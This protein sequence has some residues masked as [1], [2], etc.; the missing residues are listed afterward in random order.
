MPSTSS[1]FKTT[2]DCF[3]TYHTEPSRVHLHLMLSTTHIAIVAQT[4]RNKR[5]VVAVC[6]SHWICDSVHIGISESKINISPLS[7]QLM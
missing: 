6:T 5:V 3:N 7:N 1:T 4:P 2:K